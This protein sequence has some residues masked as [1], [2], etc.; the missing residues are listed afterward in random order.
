MR[1]YIFGV[2]LFF[3]F[4]V[5]FH[6]KAQDPQFTQI[7]ASPLYLNPA[8]AGNLDYDCRRLSA[9]RFKT[10][11]NYRSQYNGDFNTF[12]GTIDY[13]EKSGRLGI[14]G[15]VI[16]DR[17]GGSVPLNNT[18][19]ALVGSYKIPI[20]NDWQVHMGLQASFNYRNVDFSRLTFPDQFS[21]AG[22]TS[23]TNEPLLNG[24]DVSFVDFATGVLLFNDKMY[25][26]GAAHHL[27]QPNQ[28]IYSASE[29]LPLKIAVHGGYKIMFKKA[30]GFN[31]TRGPEKSLTPTIHYKGQGNFQQLEIGSF[32]NYD[33]IILGA[34][35]RGLPIF[36][37]PSGR[38]NQESV[39]FLAGV[40]VPSDFGLIKMG[41]SYDIPIGSKVN[42]LGN[43]FE[44][45]LSYQLINEKC[46]KRIV[47]RKIP[48]PGL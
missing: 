41:V 2:A 48:C 35:Y 30:R 13:R 9:S 29:K 34:W 3:G 18:Q 10:M 23:T 26:G 43:T 19:L 12:Y 32:F 27:N 17:N 42:N 37:S 36:K 31:R 38:I 15:M 28:S 22:Q 16:Y 40:K 20:I 44:V 1:N 11:V 25:I 46:R 33:P 47:Y 39:C 24:A 7:Y 21:V 4:I 45:S 5:S 8:F 6:L 14:G